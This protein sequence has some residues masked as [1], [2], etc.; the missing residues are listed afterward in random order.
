[1]CF[2]SSLTMLEYEFKATDLI[3]K[4]AFLRTA[5]CREGEGASPDPS[6]RPFT[7]MRNPNHGGLGP[8]HLTHHVLGWSILWC[9]TSWADSFCLHLPFSF[10]G[11]LTSTAPGLR[12]CRRCR[13]TH[14]P[15]C[16]CISFRVATSYWASLLQANV[17]PRKCFRLLNHV[18][19]LAKTNK[20]TTKTPTN[21]HHHQEAPQS[22]T[23]FK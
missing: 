19:V 2:V 1:M 3:F 22:P 8:S 20:Q 17:R 4:L 9:Q 11:A 14:L 16:F 21:H 10:S 18:S 23:A 5:C 12:V 7:V 6:W 15:C 13:R